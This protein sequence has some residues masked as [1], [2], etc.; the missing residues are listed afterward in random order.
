MR[1]RAAKFHARAQVSKK[2]LR[3]RPLNTANQVSGSTPHALPA[4]IAIAPLSVIEISLPANRQQI[5][6]V[7]ITDTEYLIC[8]D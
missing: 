2:L 7:R 3:P 1:N 8:E 5:A 4:N 6:T